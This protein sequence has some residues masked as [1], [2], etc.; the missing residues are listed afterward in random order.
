MHSLSEQK[1]EYYYIISCNQENVL[2]KYVYLFL[3]ISTLHKAYTLI[4][5]AYINDWRIVNHNPQVSL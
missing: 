3:S 5:W 1:D 2:S 4:L